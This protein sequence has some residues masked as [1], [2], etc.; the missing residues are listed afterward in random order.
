MS[1]LPTIPYLVVDA[2]AV[3]RIGDVS[4]SDLGYKQVRKNTNNIRKILLLYYGQS[5]IET[6][7]SFISRFREPAV[8]LLAVTRTLGSA[9]NFFDGSNNLH[10]YDLV[11][12]RQWRH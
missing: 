3:G 6:K 11:A 5:E 8:T 1:V 7:I 9:Q 10:M 12:S 4:F 2:C